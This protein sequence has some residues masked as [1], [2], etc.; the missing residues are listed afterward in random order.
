MRAV[1]V[2]TLFNSVAAKYD[3]NNRLLS[4]GTDIYWR[5]KTIEQLQDILPER[6]LDVGTGTA[7]LA[8]ASVHC[9]PHTVVGVDISKRMLE[10]GR[11][12]IKK[13]RLNSVISFI[14][15]KAESLPFRSG[16]FD[17]VITSFGVRN[18]ED[19][20]QAL[21]EMHRMLRKGGKIVVLEFSRPQSSPN[22]QVYALILRRI[23]PWIGRIVA[24]RNTV[25]SNYLPQTI[26]KFPR[27]KDFLNILKKVGFS[28]TVQ[29]QMTFG[30]ISIYSGVK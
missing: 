20:E 15:G 10:L 9:R 17:A 11:L 7:D 22:K 2:R 30:V 5:R 27:G 19:L 28:K 12:K 26:L 6:I 16:E 29:Q 24:R 14:F 3:L 23:F 18:F 1:D 25:Y 21:K 4:I 8:I 13:L